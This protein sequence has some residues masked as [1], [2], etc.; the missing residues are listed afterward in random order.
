[1]AA[2]V[3][4]AACGTS[5]DAASDRGAATTPA[6]SPLVCTTASP[7][8]KPLPKSGSQIIRGFVRAFNAGRLQQARTYLAPDEAGE[9][10]AGLAQVR[11]L[12]IVDLQD[13]Y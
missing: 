5:D 7:A 13:R 1:M 8:D 9:V 10:L 4:I 11:R 12:R 6:A 3:A 2:A